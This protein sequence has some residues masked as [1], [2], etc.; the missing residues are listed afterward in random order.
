[1][2]KL[3]KINKFLYPILSLVFF[4]LLFYILLNASINGRLFPFAFGMLFALTWANQPVYFLAP[5][6][7]VAGLLH[8]L[9]VGYAIELLVTIF[10]L[11]VP[12]FIHVL[13]KKNI[14]KWELGIYAVL[15]QVATVVLRSLADGLVVL[16]ILNVFVGLAFMYVCIVFFEAMI[17]RGLTSKFTVLEIISMFVIV[18]SLCAGL[19]NLNLFGFSFLKLFVALLIFVFASA[20]TPLLTMLLAITSGLGALISTNSALFVAPFALWAL[21]CLVF[22]SKHRIF[23]AISVLCIE[24]VISLYFNIYAFGL[25]EIMPVA[26]ACLIFLI[27]PKRLLENLATIFNF[28]KD[29]LAMKNVVNRNRELLHKRLS[30]LSEVFN[31]MNIIYRNMLKKGMTKEDVIEILIGEIK[32]KICAFCPEQNHCHCTFAENTRKVFSELI[33]IAFDRGKAT[34]LDL[35]SYLTSRC[36]QTAGILGG[37]NSLT[38]QYKKYISMAG[39]VDTSKLIIADQLLGISKVLSALGKEVNSNISFE[40]VRENKIIDDLTY[41]NIVCIDAVVFEQDIHTQSVSL[42]VRNEDKDK[43]R[44]VDCVSKVCGKKM[45]LCESFS[46]SRPNYTVLNLKTAPRF[47]CMFGV[48]QRTKNGSK[49]SGDTYSILKLDGERILFAISDGM[50]SG[51]KAE[52]ISELSISLVENFYKAGFDNE[53]ILSTI[54]KLLNLHKEDIFSALDIGIL[55]LKNGIVDFIKMASPTSFILNADSISAIKSTSLPMGIVSDVMPVVQKKVISGADLIILASDGVSDSFESDEAFEE[56]VKE[57]KTKNP[58][59]FAD[60]LLERALSN[61]NGYAVDDA[62]V[63]VIKLFEN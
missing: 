53:L 38:A 36:K 3:R 49:V 34:I 5:A 42:V 30:N 14:K 16:N 39:D 62:S 1:M 27:I 21:V 20:S 47:D 24:V 43:V 26:L 31:D 60:E 52:K 54:N 23:M 22:K 33:S 29:R 37:I 32:E 2:N 18:M 50:G 63:L 6:Y 8:N 9:S 28:S 13:A 51:E 56:C 61:N 48:A 46:S 45:T 25:V 15:S 40:T 55:D 12:Y 4:T 10:V 59:E 11:V 35:P 44:I 7:I 41:H 19:V 58:Q 57:I 17:I